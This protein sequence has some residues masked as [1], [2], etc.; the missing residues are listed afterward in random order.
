MTIINGHANI[1]YM[2]NITMYDILFHITGIALLEIS[3]FFYYI[4]PKETEMFY[5]YIQRILDSSLRD[6]EYS[7]ND[8]VDTNDIGKYGSIQLRNNTI[9]I[10]QL[11]YPTQIKM[12]ITNQTNQMQEELYQANLQGIS[13]RNTQN[14]ELFIQA[15]V[16]WAI[17]AGF[18]VTVFIIQYSYS[19]YVDNKDKKSGV[20]TVLSESQFDDIEMVSYRKTSIDGEDIE[21][22]IDG[23]D[24]ESQIDG[25]DI[26]SQIDGETKRYPRLNKICKTGSKYILFSG[27]II[28]F[29]YLFFK[30]IAFAYKPM[31]LEEIKY[32]LFTWFLSET[33]ID[34]PMEN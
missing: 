25:E 12:L 5:H 28:T 22:Q 31:S 19:K 33:N 27:C 15:I 24:I 32:Y 30:H 1:K 20:V 10:P 8:I 16:Y 11:M 34:L 26:E 17:L 6:K 18:S 2:L 29:Q 13:D 7:S 4:G 21:S 14:R 23:E 3:F 9:N